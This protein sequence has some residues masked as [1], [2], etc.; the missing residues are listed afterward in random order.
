MKALTLIFATGALL[1]AVAPT[2]NAKNGLA[3]SVSAKHSHG[4]RTIGTNL[5][6]SYQLERNL[7]GQTGCK[8]L[9]SRTRH[10]TAKASSTLGST[11]GPNG[12]TSAGVTISS[13]PTGSVCQLAPTGQ[14]VP[15]TSYPAAGGE[16][17]VY[18]CVDQPAAQ[19]AASA[20]QASEA[21]AA[22]PST[23]STT[24]NPPSDGYP[25]ESGYPDD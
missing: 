24:D 11:L 19:P 15:D 13:P 8:A 14:Y 6:N 10:Q 12:P 18:A 7:L 4:A 3:C 16:E 1:V 22:A 21:P 9:K 2:A 17:P 20:T 5:P 23:P 25:L